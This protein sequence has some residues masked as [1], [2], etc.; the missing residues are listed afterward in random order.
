[1][2]FAAR[3]LDLSTGCGFTLSV[4]KETPMTDQEFLTRFHALTL[5]PSDFG[6]AGHLRLAAL[7]L[8]THGIDAAVARTCAGIRAYAT[9]LG[10]P[11]KFHWTVTEALVRLMAA[12]GGALDGDARVLLARHYSP[13]LLASPAAR[14]GFVAPDR[15]PL[16]A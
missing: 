6:H 7:N 4:L 16:P 12:A 8:Q 11:G 2:R 9:H 15:V 14:S 1:M 5:A 13:A 3:T 10:A